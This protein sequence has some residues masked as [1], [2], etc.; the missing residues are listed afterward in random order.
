[1]P[2][3]SIVPTLCI[4]TLIEL[5]D[6]DAVEKILSELVELEEDHFIA[7][8]HRQVKKVREKAWLD[9]HIKQ[10]TFQ[11]GDSVFIYEKKIVVPWKVPNAL[12][13]SVCDKIYDRRKLFSV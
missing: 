8:F 1:M 12:V 9:I 2:M 11:M 4:A 3:D 7:G 10:K 6:F 13:G 5:I